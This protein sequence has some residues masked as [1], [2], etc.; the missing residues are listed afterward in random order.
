MGRQMTGIMGNTSALQQVAVLSQELLRD[1]GIASQFQSIVQQITSNLQMRG[2]MQN[3]PGGQQIAA[4]LNQMAL[5]P[6]QMQRAMTEML[7]DM[8]RNPSHISRVLTDSSND[9]QVMQMLQQVM[10]NFP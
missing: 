10:S 9:E 5:D 3:L 6:A 8:E 4:A 1:P 2:V 7:A